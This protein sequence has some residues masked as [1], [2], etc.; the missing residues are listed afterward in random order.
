MATSSS[1]AAAV[2]VAALAILAIGAMTGGKRLSQYLFKK[3]W[4]AQLALYES[5]PFPNLEEAMGVDNEH[6]S[7]GTFGK[8]LSQKIAAIRTFPKGTRLWKERIFWKPVIVCDDPSNMSLISKMQRSVMLR[9]IAVFLG[10]ESIIFQDGERGKHDRMHLNKAFGNSEF[11]RMQPMMGEAAIRLR[12]RMIQSQAELGYIDTV[13]EMKRTTLE[14]ICEG[15]FGYRAQ[16]SSYIASEK[17]TALLELAVSPFVFFPGGVTFIQFWHR[18][19]LSFVHSFLGNIIDERIAAPRDESKKD[20]LQLMLNI[21][22]NAL[23]PNVS[24][25]AWIRGQ[26]QLFCFAGTD[27]SSSVLSWAAALLALRPNIQEAAH[28]ELDEVC[29]AKGDDAPTMVQI[30]KLKYLEA[31]VKEV[32]RLY[33]PAPSISRVFGDD[34]EREINGIILPLDVSVRIDFTSMHRREDF[35]SDPDEVIPERWLHDGTDPR[36]PTANP[37]AWAPFAFGFRSCIGKHFAM[38]EIKTVLATLLR[39]HRFVPLKPSQA[40]PEGYY[41]KG[42]VTPNSDCNVLF[43]PR[44]SM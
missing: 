37:E 2:R 14:V 41:S 31:F 27:T 35:F 28:K 30:Q 7:R 19:T 5:L 29:G 4:K 36:L 43:V 38:I 21:D 10:E 22:E 12:D 20:L 18:D 8:P 9:K 15:G 3:W 1:A 25:S 23:P 16:N 42:L 39:Q 32:L 11:E 33:P 34:Q 44:N 24:K 40:L 17:I 6:F 13:K 26:L